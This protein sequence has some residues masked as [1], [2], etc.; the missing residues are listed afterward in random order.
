MEI[1]GREGTLV[2]VAPESPQIGV[3]R[4]Q[5]AKGSDELKDLEV[6]E[7]YSRVTPPPPAEARN[8]AEMYARFAEAIRAGRP[9]DPSFDTAVELHR[10]LD[11]LRT[12]SKEGRPVEV[13][14]R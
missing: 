7:K 5:G 13:P 11:A 8:I 12:A 3:V 1:Y 6:P 9:C 2:A 4:V 14:D 10:L